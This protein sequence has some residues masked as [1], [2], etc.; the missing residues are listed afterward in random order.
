MA[1]TKAKKARIKNLVP[2]N[3][4]EEKWKSRVKLD[5]ET[6]VCG[7]SIK[8]RHPKIKTTTLE[9]NTRELP[10]WPDVHFCCDHCTPLRKIFLELLE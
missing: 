10:F 5:A 4:Q 3:A 6:C 1:I 8:P 7:F 2:F 9:K